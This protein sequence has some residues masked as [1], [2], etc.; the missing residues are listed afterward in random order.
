MPLPLCTQMAS[1]E[2]AQLFPTLLLCPYFSLAFAV[3]REVEKLVHLYPTCVAVPDKG[4][5]RLV[6][7]QHILFMGDLAVSASLM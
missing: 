7:T 3:C 6:P 1:A 4:R 5:S 2:A